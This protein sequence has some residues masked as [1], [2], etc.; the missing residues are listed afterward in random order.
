MSTD[1]RVIEERDTG[2]GWEFTVRLGP[3]EGDAR[4]VR[5]RLAWVDYEHWSHGKHE[6]VKVADALVR[7][8][9]ERG[10]GRDLPERFDAAR[11]RR[12]Y[13]RLDAELPERL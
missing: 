5:L 12:L 6:P 11:A 8:I 1:V 9:L 4:E 13:P 3:P 10:G 7:Y 2:G